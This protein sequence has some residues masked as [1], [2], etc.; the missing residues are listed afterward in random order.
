MSKPKPFT[1]R[2]SDDDQQR[3]HEL[4]QHYDA[5]RSETL[6]KALRQAHRQHTPFP[7]SGTFAASNGV[8]FNLQLKGSRNDR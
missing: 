6:R 7:E 1:L 4:A 5:D 2:L 8:R 3:L